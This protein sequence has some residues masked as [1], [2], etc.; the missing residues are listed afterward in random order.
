MTAVD[1]SASD[2]ELVHR[3]LA[4]D[5][6]GFELLVERHRSRV[7]HLCLRVLGDAEDALDASQDAFVSALRNLDRF[8]EDAAFTT[9]LHRIAVNASY[10]L[11]RKR[12]R[13]PM[14][15]VV[16]E[17]GD[18]LAEPGPPVPDHAD[19]VVG[20]LDAGAALALVPEEF[21]V[22]LVLADVQDVAYDE[23]AQILDVPV[24]TVKSRVHR[25]RIALARAMGLDRS[26]GLD[27]TRGRTE[28]QK[29]DEEPTEGPT[30]SKEER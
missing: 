10:D 15:H 29:L 4:G 19:E 5:P 18:Q 13:A 28:D 7:Y 3:Y 21:R 1:E 17:D 23:I 25:G 22:A 16:G 12:R 2:A 14:L 26:R 20:S 6:R 24:G 27:R 11:L 9:W 8:R 30:A